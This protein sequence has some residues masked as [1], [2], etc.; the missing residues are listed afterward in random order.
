V[1]AIEECDVL[2]VGSGASGLTAAI[3]ATKAGL[4]VLIVEKEECFGGTSATSGGILWIPGN[5]HSFVLSEQTGVTDDI[6]MVRAYIRDEVGNYADRARIEAY[7]TYGKEMVDFLERETEVRF[8]GSTYPDYHSQSPHSSIVRAIGPVEYQA[9]KLG[10]NVVQLK[11]SLPQLSFFGFT[12]SSATEMKQF[13]RAL[14][15]VSG[16]GY[17]ARRVAGHLVDL[18]RFGRSDHI[19][20]GRALVAR[21][22][23]TVFD[24]SIPLWLSSPA[25]ELIVEDD[26]V[27]GATIDTPAGTVRVIAKRA[28]VLACGGY[29][30]DAKRRKATYPRL[31]G[32]S[33]HRTPT[34]PGNVGDGVRLGEKAGGRFNPAVSNPAAWMPISI[35]PGVP[36]YRGVWPH[37]ADRNKPGFIAV[38]RK[39]KRF[40]NESSSYH[41]FVPA[42]LRACEHEDAACCYLIADKRAVDHWGIGFVRPSPVPRGHHI[43]SGYLLRGNSIRELG[44]MAGIAPT[45]LENTVRNFNKHAVEGHDPDFQRGSSTYDRYQGDDENKPNPSLRPLKYAPFFAV[46]IVPGEIATF[47]GLKTDEFARVLDASDAP[48]PGLYAV[49][50]DQ[51]SV[52]G[53]AYP[54]PDRLSGPAR[55]SATSLA[56]TLL[57]ALRV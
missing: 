9:S 6:D 18:M 49:G 25:R 57:L 27:R 54:G 38:T 14:R 7:L 45:A 53:G 1:I 19:V 31:A 10:S 16:W 32:G 35:M 24:L 15:S 43:R 40:V 56:A 12:F 30:G 26:R 28:V 50:N 37:M 46:K 41:D 17:I 22:A 29:P 47:A 55:P 20:G 23:R 2:V 42:M 39:G 36:G 8:Y 3:T 21:L 51:G 11:G 4:K 5:H 48:V 34:P 52:W 13:M 33:D 44:T